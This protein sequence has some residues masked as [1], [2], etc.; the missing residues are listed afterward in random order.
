MAEKVFFAVFQT[1]G[2]HYRFSL[3]AFEPRFDD[4]PLR[5]VDH[6]WNP[7]DLRFAANK[8]QEANH[9]RFRVDHPFVHVHIE[10]V[11]AALHLL[12]GNSQSSVE[13]ASQNQLRKLRRSCDVGA[14]TNNC[15]AEFRRNI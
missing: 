13:I 10:K 5:A 6:N 8:I 15:E 9:R 12:T 1:Y 4:A 2:I 11:R 3:Q 7:C 14:L